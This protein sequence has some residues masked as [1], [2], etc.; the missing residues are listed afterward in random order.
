MDCT[1][2]LSNLYELLHNT[3][4]ITEEVKEILRKDCDEAAFVLKPWQMKT[5]IEK[6][7]NEN[8]CICKKVI[9]I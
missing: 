9:A 4:L 2:N 1:L 3:L 8:I 7:I 6:R 5:V